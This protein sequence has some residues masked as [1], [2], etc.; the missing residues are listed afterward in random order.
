MPTT[1]YL[2]PPPTSLGSAL[3]PTDYQWMLIVQGLIPLYEVDTSKGSYTEALPPA[4]VG[5]SGQTGQC[6]EIIYLKTSADAN[7]DTIT[8]AITGPVVL[9]TQWQVARFK[10]D[11]TNWYAVGAAAGSAVEI[12]IG[13]VPNSLQTILNFIAGSGV[14]ITNPSGGEVEISATG[15]G[16]GGF[17][18][19]AN[20]ALLPLYAHVSAGLDGYTI[21]LHIPASYVMAFRASGCKVGIVTTATLGLVVNAASVGATLPDSTVWS[22]AP[23]AFTWPAGSF[24]SALTLYLSNT[25]AIAM[26]ASHDYYIAVYF[27]PTSSGG[28]AYATE[29]TI[30]PV[31][32]AAGLYSANLAGYLSGDH[33]NDADATA[34]QS[35]AG[36][37]IFCVQQVLTA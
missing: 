2:P 9:A 11:G 17:P 23:T 28:N 25:C 18:T 35:L 3:S 29:D 32:A 21:V 14:T 8:G 37:S 20:V 12:E 27:D 22:T 34:F 4:G 19:G 31:T 5:S 6:K 26:D 13:G 24:L 15:G 16:G 30:T 1:P 36:N 33:S 10:S 7:T